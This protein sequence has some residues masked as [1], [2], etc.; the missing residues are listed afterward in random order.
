MDHGPPCDHRKFVTFRQAV[1]L[2]ERYDVLQARVR[3]ARLDRIEKCTMLKEERG[4]LTT[5]CGPQQA[6][7]IGRV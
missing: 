4:I 1:Q 6:G 7:G 2:P 3:S 5:Q